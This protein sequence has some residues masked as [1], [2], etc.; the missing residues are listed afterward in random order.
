MRAKVC[1]C[2]WM[3][4]NQVVKSKILIIKRVKGTSI[5]FSAGK[6]KKNCNVFEYLVNMVIKARF[7][8]K[9]F[10]IGCLKCTNNRIISV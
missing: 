7:V 8:L 9:G 3:L 2:V 1:E 4:G 6:K 5:Y 10:V